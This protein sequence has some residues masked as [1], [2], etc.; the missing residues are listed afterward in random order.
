[1]YESRKKRRER[2]WTIAKGTAEH[3]LCNL[4]HLPIFTTDRWDESHFP[5][6]K[7][8]GGK[9]T[10]IA[11]T[12][13]N[14]RHGQQVVWPLLA[15]ADRIRARHIGADGP[16]MGPRA[17]ACGRRSRLRKTIAGRIVERLTLQQKLLSAGVIDP[18]AIAAAMK[19]EIED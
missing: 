5:V 14:R 1:M 17:M 13:C 15:K 9:A 6:P 11:H 19:P 18:A 7:S 2:L 12:L 3:P 4:C 8:F 10:G 16:G